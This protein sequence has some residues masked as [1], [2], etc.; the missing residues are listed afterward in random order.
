MAAP[1]LLYTQNTP[2]GQKISIALEELGLSYQTY[3]LDFSK[4]E[5]KEDWY[6]K[7]NPNGR[8]PAIVD[9]QRCNFNVFE[10]GSIMLYLAE[11]YDPEHILLPVDSDKRS[12]VISWL[13]WQNAGI[14]PMQGQ[15][16]HFV[17][18]APEKIPYAIKR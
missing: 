15:A 5:Q 12:Q 2:N 10:S 18:Y 1:I 9:Q 17:K 3:K 7:I 16:N 13:F 8:I 11:H 6:L 4:N 14:G